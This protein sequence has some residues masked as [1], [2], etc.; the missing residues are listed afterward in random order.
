MS[1]EAVKREAKTRGKSTMKVSSDEYA[2]L[3]LEWYAPLIGRSFRCQDSEAEKLAAR[4]RWS[5]AIATIWGST[6]VSRLSSLV[7]LTF[8]FTWESASQP[9]ASH[10]ATSPVTQLNLCS[11]TRPNLQWLATSL[12]ARAW[13]A[14]S[15]SALKR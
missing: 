15:T 10:V 12:L 4:T 2:S 13:A 9:S 8:T 11:C 5:G 1:V 7:S 6:D 3:R 14:R